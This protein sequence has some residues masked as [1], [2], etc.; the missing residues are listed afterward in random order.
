[1][2]R[3]LPPSV[4]YES[5]QLSSIILRFGSMGGT[6]SVY[7]N[8]L[9]LLV[10]PPTTPGRSDE[11]VLAH[12]VVQ[13][14]S[15]IAAPDVRYFIGHLQFVADPGGLPGKISTYSWNGQWYVRHRAQRPR[16]RESRELRP[17]CSQSSLVRGSRGLRDVL[18]GRGENF[19]SRSK[20]DRW[21][22]AWH[23]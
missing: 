5:R 14:M 22:A 23:S 20:L 16:F 9:P 15:K 2:Q 1:M 7:P 3:R 18:R 4:V 12:D 10:S 6:R 21:F 8:C 17:S 13:R 11:F 19:L